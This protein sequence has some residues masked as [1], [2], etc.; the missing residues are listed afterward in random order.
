MKCRNKVKQF[1]V[2]F[3]AYNVS[4]YFLISFLFGKYIF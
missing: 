3:A 1:N 4:V 2:I